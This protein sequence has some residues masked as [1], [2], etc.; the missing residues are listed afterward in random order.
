MKDEDFELTSEKTWDIL[1]NSPEMPIIDQFPHLAD[2]ISLDGRTVLLQTRQGIYTFGSSRFVTT[3]PLDSIR[4]SQEENFLVWIQDQVTP[5]G[6]FLCHRN[7]Q[8]YEYPGYQDGRL[9]GDHDGYFPA[10]LKDLKLG[11]STY[12]C[13]VKDEYRGQG[14]GDLAHTLM[15]ALL[16]KNGFPYFDVYLDFTHSSRYKSG[17]DSLN[18]SGVLRLPGKWEDGVNYSFYTRYLLPN[19]KSGIHWETRLSTWQINLLR[20]SQL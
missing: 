1:N 17:S 4:T 9:Y 10:T 3:V 15:L 13:Y 11:D 14:I 16:Q 6:Y 19:C 7:P 18:K 2:L 5:V 20:Q 8:N 12:A